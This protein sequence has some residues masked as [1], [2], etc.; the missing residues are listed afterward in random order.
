MKENHKDNRDE[1]FQLLKELSKASVKFVVCGGVASVLYGVE[2]ATYDLDISVSLDNENLKKIIKV[3]DK[4]KLKPRIPEP[5][6]NLL[7]DSKRKEWVEKKGA[8]VYTFTSTKGPMQLDIFLSHPKS[9]KELMRTAK[10][11][12][13]GDYN[14][15]VSSIEDLIF[16]KKKVVPLRDKDLIDIKELEEIKKNNN[17]KEKKKN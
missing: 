1:L 8:L 9:Y 2:R 12:R 5:V 16:S 7:D 3:A 14:I 6:E 15:R 4:F 13:I 10:L 11:V 17:E